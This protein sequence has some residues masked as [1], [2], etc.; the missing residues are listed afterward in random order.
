[1]ENIYLSFS[2]LVLPIPFYFDFR[3]T[4]YHCHIYCSFPWLIIF[5][6]YNLANTKI[7]ENDLVKLFAP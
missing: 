4:D 1:M 7:V 5:E 2:L 6:N 3:F